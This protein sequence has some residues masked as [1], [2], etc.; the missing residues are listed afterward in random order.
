VGRK[1]VVSV[2]IDSDV[3]N[4]IKAR[5]GSL[6][7][8]V[9]KAVRDYIGSLEDAG[10]SAVDSAVD[11][12]LNQFNDKAIEYV[13]SVK[14]MCREHAETVAQSQNVDREFIYE[15]CLWSLRRHVYNT[16]KI[17]YEERV[18]PLLRRY[19]RDAQTQSKVEHRAIEIINNAVKEL[20]PY[21]YPPVKPP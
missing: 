19:I 1:K 16:L 18:K 5:Y 15:N 4:K 14:G 8:F 13:E 3:L 6:T 20:Y 2:R 9:K 21:P 10:G 12:V 11:D 7:S 17:Y